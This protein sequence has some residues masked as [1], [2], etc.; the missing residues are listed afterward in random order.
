[1][2]RAVIPALV[3]VMAV[4]LGTAETAYMPPAPGTIVT[5]KYQLEDQTFLQLSEVVASGGDFVVYDPNLGEAASRPVDFQVEFSGLHTQTCDQPL[6][7]EDDRKALASI[8]PLIRGA[9][10]SV[11]SGVD[12]RYQVDE[13]SEIALLSDVEGAGEVWTVSARMGEAEMQIAVSPALGMPVR[14][15]WPSGEFG[16]VIE[17]VEPQGSAAPERDDSLD[18]GFCE[19]LLQ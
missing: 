1:M 15:G 4:P 6:P 14:L 9:S 2:M 8:W 18:L 12:S 3:A 10:A 17:V 16:Q 19:E 7:A 13:A 11:R 5:W